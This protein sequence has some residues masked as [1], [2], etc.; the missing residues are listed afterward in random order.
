MVKKVK[1]RVS[2]KGGDEVGKTTKKREQAFVK[3]IKI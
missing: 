2:T 3:K 1:F